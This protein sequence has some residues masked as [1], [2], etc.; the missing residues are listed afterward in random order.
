MGDGYGCIGVWVYGH[1]CFTMNGHRFPFM[2]VIHKL[3]SIHPMPKAMALRAKHETIGGA[4]RNQTVS[5]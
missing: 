3:F 2:A 1:G 5:T 4:T